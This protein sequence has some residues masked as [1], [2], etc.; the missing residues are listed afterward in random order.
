[1]L[2]GYSGHVELPQEM[3]VNLAGSVE[4]SMCAARV[5]CSGI[6]NPRLAS[7]AR[8]VSIAMDYSGTSSSAPG[9]S[10]LPQAPASAKIATAP[11]TCQIRRTSSPLNDTPSPYVRSA[12]DVFYSQLIRGAVIVQ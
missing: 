10:S 12:G 4:Y 11:T 7:S 1:M 9:S 5:S 8:D 2:V 6:S 3:S